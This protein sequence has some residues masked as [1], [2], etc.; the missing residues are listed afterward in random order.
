M[1]CTIYIWGNPNDKYSQVPNDYARGI[2]EKLAAK[3]CDDCPNMMMIHRDN[4]SMYY[5]G[6]LQI[7]TQH[8]L[9]ITILMSNVIIYDVDTMFKLMKWTFEELAKQNIIL[10]YDRK[11]QI[12]I[13]RSH[14]DD[15]TRH[16]EELDTAIEIVERMFSDIDE[17]CK[18]LPPL[19]YSRSNTEFTTIFATTTP[20]NEEVI[21]SYTTIYVISDVKQG[22]VQRAFSIA[23]TIYLDFKDCVNVSVR[24]VSSSKDTFAS[25]SVF[26]KLM[27]MLLL[28]TLITPFAILWDLLVILLFI[29]VVCI[30]WGLAAAVGAGVIWACFEVLK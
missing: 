19:D 22:K 21:K 26:R 17:L 24:W 3:R 13:F 8:Y 16:N 6:M 4:N 9:G 1:N 15:L 20:A 12:I 25:L 7:D 11:G 29:V 28:I 14:I 30:V 5:I 27:S 18:P 23:S 2:F 10:C